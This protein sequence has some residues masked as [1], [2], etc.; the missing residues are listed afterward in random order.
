MSISSTL[1]RDIEEKLQRNES[2]LQRA[3]YDSQPS[4]GIPQQPQYQLVSPPL[5]PLPYGHSTHQ[6]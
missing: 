1:Y 6:P 5:P 2:H 3:A 4:Y